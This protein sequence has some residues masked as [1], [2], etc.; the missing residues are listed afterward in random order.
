MATTVDT[1]AVS[2]NILQ[3]NVSASDTTPLSKTHAQLTDYCA[4]GPLKQ[5][6]TTLTTAQFNALNNDTRLRVTAYATAGSTPPAVRVAFGGGN[7]LFALS[8]SGS[9]AIKFELVSSIDGPKTP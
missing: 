1:Q 5:F 4:Q 2:P 6:L 3:L 8:G 7:M 9:A